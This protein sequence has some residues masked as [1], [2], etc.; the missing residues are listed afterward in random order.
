M[1]IVAAVPILLAIFL[2]GDDEPTATT[3]TP[4]PTQVL[5]RSFEG[6]GSTSTGV[7]VVGADWILKWQLDGL[8]TDSLRISVRAAGGQD[9]ETVLQ[10]GLGQGERAFAVG[11]A[12]RLVISSTGEWSIRVLQVSNPIGK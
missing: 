11:G 10:D 1:L 3:S 4:G 7:F 5:V 2:T 6:D 12:Y 8:A 9:S